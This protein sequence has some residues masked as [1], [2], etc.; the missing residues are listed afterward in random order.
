VPDGYRAAKASARELIAARDKRLEHGTADDRRAGS[1]AVLVIRDAFVRPGEG[2]PSP[3]TRLLGN[4][5]G[6]DRAV[7]LKVFLTL[8]WMRSSVTKAGDQ[9]ATLDIPTDALAEIVN[10]RGIGHAAAVRDANAALRSLA[11]R[12]FVRL[13]LRRGRSSPGAASSTAVRGPSL[14]L[15]SDDGSGEPHKP[16]VS[17]AEPWFA[18]GESFFTRAWITAMPGAALATF[19]IY[20][21]RMSRQAPLAPMWIARSRLREWYGISPESFARGAQWLVRHGVMRRVTRKASDGSQKS[22]VK[23]R[24]LDTHEWI[25]P[26]SDVRDG[27]PQPLRAMYLSNGF[28]PDE[29]HVVAHRFA[30]R[31]SKAVAPESTAPLELPT[32]LGDTVAGEDPF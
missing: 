12:H 21:S 10:A 31:R 22:Q 32:W 27:G 17:G 8:L 24:F 4:G 15:L 5:R 3:M 29:D 9:P 2:G 20:R 13:D 19:L 1:D 7:Q 14:V 11:D 16:P 6:W 28:R 25:N 23:H 26:Y 18:L 30:G